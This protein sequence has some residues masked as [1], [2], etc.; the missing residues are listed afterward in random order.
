MFHF[1]RLRT[2]LVLAVLTGSVA[3]TFA[4]EPAPTPPTEPAP[5]EPAPPVEQAP[6][7]EQAPSA[8]EQPPS[9]APAADAKP[10]GKVTGRAVDKSTNEGL[11]AA[12]L[13][14]KGP[15]G[16][17][18]VVTELDG[19]F[20]LE[21]A[22]GT[23]SIL[24]ST[25][26]YIDEERKVVVAADKVATLDVALAMIPQKAA[27]ETIEVFDTIDTSKSSAILAE[28]RAA[29]T[30]SDAISKE[31]IARS[32][33]SNGAD[34]AKRMVA[35]T[36]QDNR[37]IVVRG[38][39]GR[40]S[41]TLL[42]GVPLPSP[43]PDVPA[44]PLD[45]FPASLITNLTVNKT[46]SPDMP[47]NFAGG[48]LGIETRA[49]PTK[50]TF[51][52]KLG[53]GNNTQS[54]FRTLNTQQGGALDMFGFD[55][56]TRA[57]PSVIPE[58]KLAGDPSLSAAQANA[59]IAAFKN[60]WSLGRQTAGPNLSMNATLGNTH[61]VEGHR[62]GYLGSF[63]FGHG[64]ASRV[65]HIA[66]P[67]ASDGMGGTLP[68][69]LQ[70]EDNA[71]IEQANLSAIGSA[72]WSPKSGHK[73]DWFTLYSHN[74]DITSSSVTG[75][76]H[77]GTLV[78]RTR[79]QFLQ[80][81][82]MF[83]QLVGEHKLAPR[84]IL[85]WQGNVARVGQNEPDTK[86]LMR[87]PTD[88]GRMAINTN[89]GSSERLFGTL[90]DFTVGG[91]AAVRIPL[92]SVRFK[93]G[94]SI[95]RSTREY[96]QRRFHF[97]LLGDS[98]YLDPSE[99][100]EPENAGLAMSMYEVTLPS[101][102]YTGTRTVAAGY[103]MADVNLTPELRV[104][105][106]ARFERADLDVGLES[107]IDLGAPPMPH[108]I[109]G[110][111]DFL[112]S[113]N[114]VYAVTPS[115]NVRAAYGMTIA[116]PNFREIAPALYFDYVRLRALGGNPELVDTRIH[117]GDLRWETFLG[118]NEV[119][120]ASVFAKQFYNP[121]ER[122]LEPAGDGDNVGFANAPSARSYGVELEARISLG[123]LADALS[124]FSVGGNLSLIR[125]QISMSGKA[126]PLQGQSP[127]V[128]NLGLGYE[129]KSLGTR[130]DLLYNSFGK[131][132]EELG[133][134]GYGNIYEQ[135]FHRFDVAASQPMGRS[136]RFK[137][138]GSNL[139]DQRVVRIQDNTDIYSFKPGV[140]V[141]GS[142]ELSLE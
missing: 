47:G 7:A 95:Q 76:L 114:A 42:N 94:T 51:K 78:D 19:T 20:T 93:V 138:T 81:E 124:Q 29:A 106:G 18:S 99:A 98:A 107:K 55:D 100:F 90:S 1:D 15:D 83:T 118:D 141:V 27:E 36:V 108:T 33:D 117:N 85:E 13:I 84:A 38:L 65:A 88:D 61:K 68:S 119:I 112:P 135:P 77:S 86:D 52:A 110:T 70:L 26:D 57:L 82:L 129:S 4:E 54:S 5:A 139:L 3:P 48:A 140:T 79:L 37:Y 133:T 46:F 116:R 91:G 49:Y 130:I 12:T 92:D 31:Q 134:G 137:L 64:Y 71:G 102:G 105:G 67:S 109:R 101:D 45:L 74:A 126:R 125:S 136:M 87:L 127:Y 62:V 40:Y 97:N 111:N 28:R 56:G 58:Y 25:P 22:P 131:R 2:L 96:Q 50:F 43:D 75:T 23:Y 132:I 53:F 142:L 39:G 128:A 21:L 9:E 69:T 89:P 66:R 72:G 34:A 10:K 104:I 123:R 24:V 41:T 113:L 60:T 122:T 8:D 14:V 121:I 11:P 59:Q 115:S 32:P 63:S 73:V 103:A 120:A 44:A 35:A 30:V 6:P 80:R 16:N 17:Q